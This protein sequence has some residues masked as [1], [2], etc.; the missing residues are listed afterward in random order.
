MWEEIHGFE[1][2]KKM[3]AEKSKQMTGKDPSTYPN[4]QGGISFEPYSLEFN[5][6]LREQI[7]KRD[8]YRCQICF[9]HQSELL[10]KTGRF[11]KLD[12]HHIDY[13]KKNSKSKNL[14]SLC[15]NGN[16][17]VNANKEYWIAC[18]KEKIIKKEN[19]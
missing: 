8:G 4:W 11:R 15:M 13:D 19:D 6:E 3:K 5:N 17:K 2:A 9:R 10:T 1:R 7:R 14:I 18:F 16:V 12:I